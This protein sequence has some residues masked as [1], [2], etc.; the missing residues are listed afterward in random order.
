[1]RAKAVTE[2]RLIQL[3]E[4]AH[5]TTDATAVKG[6]EL[7]I[8]SEYTFNWLVE[9]SQ[10]Q[11]QPE[12]VLEVSGDRQVRLGSMVGYMQSPDGTGIEVLPKTGF[13]VDKP[14]RTRALLQKMLGSTLSVSSKEYQ[15]ASL[16]TLNT[17]IH[18]WIFSMF[19]RELSQLLRQGLRFQ[20]ERVE[21]QERFIRGQLN[22]AKQMRQSPAKAAEFNVSYDFFSPN[23]LENR[24]IKTAL[25]FV[26]KA[27]KEA[28]NWRLA[29]EFSHYLEDIRAVANP[30][31]LLANWEQSKAL[32]HY[33]L[34]H[35][36]CELI[37]KN[38]NPA[39]VK[40]QQQGIALMFPMER[41]FE[42]YVTK[43][44][45]RSTVKGAKLK[46]QASSMSLVKHASTENKEFEKWFLLKPDLLLTTDLQV[47]VIDL[48]WKLL[49]QEL[50]SANDKYLISQGDM[51][52]L[53]AYGQKYQQGV[54]N[55]MLVYPKHKGFDAP[56]PPFHF[57]ESLT[58]WAVPYCLE[59][60]RLIHGAWR[61][62]F[63]GFR[64]CLIS[65]K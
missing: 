15:S 40:G 59:T 16:Q 63:L 20:Y 14:E 54:G 22:I 2:S 48:K 9:L 7:G 29:N 6:P 50:S 5:I 64:N 10:R 30:S 58:L 13:A 19:L 62:H 3:V 65:E 53:L 34:I 46:P 35:P 25:V 31:M 42:S 45:D 38:L 28:E 55:M 41:L 47:S 23:L 18:E 27:C 8:V 32:K 56:L 36:W 60:D 33:Q 44:L 24:L 21:G 17:P 61:K 51:Y 57:D 49:D 52:Q 26:L 11:K 4:Y 37:L 12:K 39:F 43:L 1:M